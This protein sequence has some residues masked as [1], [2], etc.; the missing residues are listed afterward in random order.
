MQILFRYSRE[1]ALQ[2]LLQGPGLGTTFC[3]KA[4][5][6]AGQTKNDAADYNRAAERVVDEYRYHRML[7]HRIGDFYG[8]ERR[9]STACLILA[10]VHSVF[11]GIESMCRTRLNTEGFPQVIS[12]EQP[13]NSFISRTVVFVRTSIYFSLLQ[14][15]LVANTSC[16]TCGK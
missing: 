8:M 15:L 13:R 10:S 12:C 11:I 3:A 1:R 9:V 2:S 4:G 7:V 6:P 14:F 16:Y 5:Q